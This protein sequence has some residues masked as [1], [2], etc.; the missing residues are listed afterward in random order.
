MPGG[1]LSMRNLLTS[2]FIS[3]RAGSVG[4][5]HSSS[6]ADLV[7][8]PDLVL[9]REIARGRPR[10][11]SDGVFRNHSATRQAERYPKCSPGQHTIEPNGDVWDTSA[12]HPRETV[13][14]CNHRTE[15][16]A[17]PQGKLRVSNADSF[18]SARKPIRNCSNSP[19]PCAASCEEAVARR[20]H[21]EARILLLASG[22]H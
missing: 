14:D 9:C 13:P 4:F 3:H 17:G 8:L 6:R 16:G 5:R 19:I 11:T 15:M 12:W 21:F 20:M 2:D 18:T 7:S 22:R 10:R 1:V